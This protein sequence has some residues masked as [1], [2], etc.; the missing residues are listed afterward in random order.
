MSASSQR[1]VAILTG[2]EPDLDPR[3]DWVAS[4]APAS[5]ERFVFGFFNSRRVRLATELR[6]GAYQIF[7]FRRIR[8]WR[9][10][11][12]IWLFAFIRQRSM[13]SALGMAFVLLAGLAY[14]I[15]IMMLWLPIAL[16]RKAIRRIG[17]SFSPDSD[18]LNLIHSIDL[19]LGRVRN[20][21]ILRPH[22]LLVFTDVV[23]DFFGTTQGLVE[24]VSANLQHF[25]TVQASDLETLFAGI[26]LKMKFDARLI[27]DAHEFWPHADVEA[28]KWEIFFWEIV[29]NELLKSVDAAFTV[30]DP[31]AETMSAR[32]K[33]KFGAVPNCEPLSSLDLDSWHTGTL[34]FVFQGGFAEKRGVDFLLRAWKLANLKNAQLILRGPDSESKSQS[35]AMAKS[36]GLLS[37]S[38]VFAD[39]VE[40]T[41][42]LSV[43][44][45]CSVGI[46]PYEP[47]GLNYRYCCPNKLSQYMK[48]GLAVLHNDLPY[49]D[50]I[51][52]KAGCGW[53]YDGTNIDLAAEKLRAIA[54]NTQEIKVKG[55]RARSYFES[56][57][58]WQS[59]SEPMYLSYCPSGVASVN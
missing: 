44:Q 1:R 18:W 25:D 28:R 39:S 35:I 42:L 52:S 37:D 23:Q 20:L 31:L 40:E 7:R 11:S 29:E 38:V 41:E 8:K 9:V 33:K 34:K 24:G 12:L 56:V 47:F 10:L 32:Y 6:N 16:L 14:E 50:S 53:R 45:G 13:V 43:L 30:S 3:I 46:V 4:F 55:A 2:S 19:F 27:Y 51:V 17:H 48:S 59:V 22:R 5:F 58:N 54:Q 15:P 36:L 26:T 21:P 49:V 57:F